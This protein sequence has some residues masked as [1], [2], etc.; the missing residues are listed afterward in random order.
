MNTPQKKENLFYK[1]AISVFSV[2]FLPVLFC[3]IFLDKKIPY[4]DSCRLAT[5][6]PNVVLFAVGILALLIACVMI[7]K[8]RN[9]N[10][11]RSEIEL[12]LFLVL[13]FLALYH[14]NV[15]IARETVY[16][17]GWDAE[18]IRG[19][20]YLLDA[21]TPLGYDLYLV[22]YPNNIP[23]S[24]VLG[25]LY[26][27]ANWLGNSY[28]YNSEFIW[29]QVACM[30]ISVAGL[31]VCCA[32]KR[33]VKNKITVYLSV[34]MYIACIGLTPWKTIPYTDVYSIAFPA[35]SICFYVY[36]RYCGNK[37]GKAVYLILAFLSCGLGG[38]IKP[39]VYIALIAIIVVEAG[40]VIFDKGR[41][42]WKWLLAEM[43]LLLAVVCGARY[44]E[45][46]MVQQMGLTQNRDI[47]ATWHHFFYMG[48]NEETTGGDNS[49]DH[50]M[51]GEFQFQPIE[52]RNQA[53]LERAFGRI[54][55][56]GVF[57]SLYF[58]LKKMVMTFNDGTFGWQLEG[59]YKSAFA[60]IAKYGKMTNL[61]RFIF[62]A[63]NKYCG[64]Y[65]TF[66]Q[67]VWIAVLSCLPGVCL[68]GRDKE[69]MNSLFLIHFVGV[70]LYILLFEA[71]ARYL[72]CFVPV[73][74]AQ[75]ALGL[76]R[77]STCVFKWISD[78]RMK[79][80]GRSKE[81]ASAGVH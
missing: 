24:Y 21:G 5:L 33:I 34:V 40:R 50:G 39:T 70:F 56:R 36:Y 11:K 12:N 35:L 8:G 43:I 72:L 41:R 49:N 15:Y 67:F 18:V 71:R 2:L 74:I 68:G 10:G 54:R 47:A 60:P 55:E 58:W 62:W 3:I 59:Y 69:G 65:N 63:N 48:L 81:D 57:G 42:P 13:I 80:Y 45:Q 23:I 44:A 52:V 6:L 31:A 1:M 53:E 26:T 17:T 73:L 66:C 61:L 79:R 32:V 78:W 27:F 76:D 38:L 77:Y 19:Y 9:I 29:N 30:F 51:F 16:Y 75:A 14:V 28:A 4:Y 20:A 22:M 37:I 46:Q 64:Q 7:H 25:K